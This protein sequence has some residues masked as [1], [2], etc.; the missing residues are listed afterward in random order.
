LGYL[1]VQGWGFL[2]YR[3]YKAEA[4]PT[5]LTH[6]CIP[7]S[8]FATSALGR[9]SVFF[10]VPFDWSPYFV[11]ALFLLLIILVAPPSGNDFVADFGFIPLC[12]NNTPTPKQE[13]FSL[14]GF[15]DFFFWSAFSLLFT[16]GPHFDGFKGVIPLF[17]HRKHAWGKSLR[18]T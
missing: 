14:P 7:F 18:H 10:F 12:K 6:G 5:P 1:N 3:K 11:C 16:T 17:F 2:W 9:Q 15:V 4:P 8:V 13:F